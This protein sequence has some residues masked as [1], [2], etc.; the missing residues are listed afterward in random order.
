VPLRTHFAPSI[1]S[2]RR[3]WYWHCSFGIVSISKIPFRGRHPLNLQATD[4]G[5]LPEVR[6]RIRPFQSGFTLVEVM[7]GLAVVTI[8][9]GACYVGIAYSF[10]QLRL[11]RENLRATQILSGKMEVLRE[12]N[13]DQ[14]ANYSGYIPTHFT[15]TFFADNPTNSNT[16]FT[17]SGMVIVTNVPS[18]T[19]SYS[20]DLR[21]IQIN[22]TWKS[23]GLV[24]KRQ[25][26]TFVSQYGLQRYV[27]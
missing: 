7:V 1:R 4:P 25:A 24:H 15:E 27:Y 17:Y 5:N 18:M 14:V 10:N 26:T 23:G 8:M 13:W 9:G 19:E 16:N 21:M 22:L 2:N 12:F 6:A 20:N 11:A 3:F